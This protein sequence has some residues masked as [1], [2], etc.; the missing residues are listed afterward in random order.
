MKASLDKL[1]VSIEQAQ[2]GLSHKIAVF[3]AD[4]TLWPEDVGFGFF[5][6]QV[7]NNLLPYKDFFKSIDECYKENKIKTCSIIL[8]KNKGVLFDQYLSW[9][10]SFFKTD[11]L[12]IFSFQKE[13]IKY[14][15]KLDVT[16]YVVSASPQWVVQQAVRHY[17]L[18]V[19]VVVGLKT[20][21]DDKRVITDQLV[22]PLSMDSGKVTAFLERSKNIYPFF[23]SGNTV[24]DLDLL[25]SSTHIK[26]VV[27]K[28]QKEERQY[29]SEQVLLSIA[30]QKNWFYFS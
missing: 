26:C 4:G 12:T 16:V 14:L 30:R 25:E 3:D 2:R 8:Q 19:D 11:P 20:V 21:V 17:E 28:A 7:K 9:C 24:S 5:E 10:Q 23:A 15:K 13:L 27:A 29:E 1:M 18:P 6:Y 22:Y